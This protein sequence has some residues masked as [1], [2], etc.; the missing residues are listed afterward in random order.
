[1]A[2]R[3]EQQ[4]AARYHDICDLSAAERVLMRHARQEP[5]AARQQQMGQLITDLALVRM[6]LSKQQEVSK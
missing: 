6:A 4:A 1:M 3:A 5:D 2:T